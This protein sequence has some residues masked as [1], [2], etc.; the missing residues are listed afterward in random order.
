MLSSKVY[1]WQ[2]SFFPLI[3]LIDFKLNLRFVNRIK[4]KCNFLGGHAVTPLP[5]LPP[6]KKRKATQIL[7]PTQLSS[8]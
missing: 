1:Q 2:F 7:R 3:Y 5:L 6:D 8:H 4:H